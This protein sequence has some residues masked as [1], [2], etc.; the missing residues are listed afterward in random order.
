MPKSTFQW[1][2][3]VVTGTFVVDDDAP[4]RLVRLV[5][6]A[7]LDDGPAPDTAQPLVEVFAFGQGHARANLR[8]TASAIGD[9][10]R[11]RGHTTSRQDGWEQV[12]I[13]QADALTGLV[14]R[15]VLRC[16]DDVAAVQ[17]STQVVNEGS[18]RVVL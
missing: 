14:V 13:E 3:G 12:V 2:N 5:A 7:A 15:S 16:A 11:Y 8:Y 18:E 4:V 17:G 1:G 9:R 6:G 10:L